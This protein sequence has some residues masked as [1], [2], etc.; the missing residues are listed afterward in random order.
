MSREILR[1]D[2]PE[3]VLIYKVRGLAYVWK[4]REISIA[5]GK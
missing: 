4:N 5:A 1:C 2:L 3:S